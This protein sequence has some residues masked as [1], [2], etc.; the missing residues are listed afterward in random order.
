VHLDLEDSGGFELA[1][2]QVKHSNIHTVIVYIFFIILLNVKVCRV[3]TK[4]VLN[5]VGQVVAFVVG[6]V[7]AD[8][9]AV[10]SG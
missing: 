5:A 2:R 10:R 7:C 6:S 4:C 1:C 9:R 3:Y 8:Q